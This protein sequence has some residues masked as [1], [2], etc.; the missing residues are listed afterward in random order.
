MYWKFC[1]FAAL[2]KVVVPGCWSTTS[3]AAGVV[4]IDCQLI[5]KHYLI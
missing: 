5:Y 3:G 4:S 1:A 2:G